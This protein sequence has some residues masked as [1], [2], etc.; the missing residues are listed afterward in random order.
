MNNHYKD[1][2]YTGEGEGFGGPI[3]V[4]VTVKDGQITKVNIDSA[5]DET[6]AYFNQAKTLVNTIIEKQVWKL[7]A[8][9]GA[10]FSS[11]GILE[12]VSNAMAATEDKQ[13]PTVKYKDGVYTGSGIGYD[14]SNIKVQ[15][16]I[17]GGKI[18]AIE[19]LEA[20][21]ESPVYKKSASGVIEGVLEK[22]DWDVDSIVGATYSSNGIKEAIAEALSKAEVKEEE[23]TP[24]PTPTPAEDAKDTVYTATVMVNPD[25][26]EDF[27]PYEMTLTITVRT[28]NGTNTI[29]SSEVTSDTNKT[30]KKYLDK[31]WSGMQSGLMSSGSAD[32]VSGATCSS[33]AI[34]SAWSQASGKIS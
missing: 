33:N 30:N 22:Q 11:E 19:I 4:T 34:R 20:E 12:A 23:V 21:K 27:E 31:A 13:E 6:P 28:Q 9:S 7:D 8:V 26:D 5:E 17:K 16:T 18:T 24:T 2:T 29:I 32:A 25:E 14:H 1:G 15:V 3:K 10:T